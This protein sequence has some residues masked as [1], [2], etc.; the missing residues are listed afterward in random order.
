MPA[1][2]MDVGSPSES[3]DENEKIDD[4]KNNATNEQI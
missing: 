2:E 1:G 3:Q 4:C